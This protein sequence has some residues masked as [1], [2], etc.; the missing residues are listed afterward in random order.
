MVER[1]AVDWIAAGF[2]PAAFWIQTM[3]GV[4]R[5]LR[6]AARAAR[7]RL[8]EATHAAWLGRNL[9]QA[10]LQQVLDEL[11]R[12][13]GSRVAPTTAALAASMASMN[14]KLGAITMDDYRK[15]LRGKG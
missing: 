12:P 9:D 1:L 7:L 10:G 8:A 14:S 4:Q 6:G 2:D 3:R 5:A 15:R 13:Q 11:S